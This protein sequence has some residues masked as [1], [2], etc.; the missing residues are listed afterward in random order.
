MY[1]HSSR[2]DDVGSTL[3]LLGF[4]AALLL[5]WVVVRLLSFVVRTFILHY[6][7]IGLWYS[8]AICIV[9]CA[10]GVL[11]LAL[12]LSPV[13]VV[14]PIVGLVQFLVVCLIVS[15]RGRQTLLAEKSPGLVHQ[16]LGSNWWS[17]ND[18]PLQPGSTNL[19][20]A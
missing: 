8:L 2:N 9:L 13:F 6:K 20:A 12:R 1:H 16:I 17:D 18:V 7:H 11:L 14:L 10:V 19:L 5:A 4:V 3:V 15:L